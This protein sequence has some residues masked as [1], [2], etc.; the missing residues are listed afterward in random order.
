MELQEDG[1]LL[2]RHGA[3]DLGQGSNS[4]MCEIAAR[5]FGVDYDLVQGITGDTREGKDGGITAASRQTHITG[6]AAFEVSEMF[7]TTL[8]KYAAE[9]Y[10]ADP[11]R[12]AVT[13]EGDLIDLIKEEPV[14]DLRDLAQKVKEREEELSVSHHYVPQQTYRILNAQQRKEADIDEDAYINYPAFCYGCQVAV[15][16]VDL[17]TGQVDVIKMIAAHDAGTAILP[18]SVE[19]QIEGGVVMGL[20][21]ALTEE[22]VEEE[23]VIISDSLYKLTAPRSTNPADVE[24]IIVEDP[25]PRGPFGAKGVGEGAYMPTAP[26]VINAIDNATGIR[27]RSIPATRDKIMAAILEERQE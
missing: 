27:I 26:A 5:A 22:F 16:E 11:E 15:V 6:Q 8:L 7:K 17:E 12:L 24:A 23:G 18:T 25:H 4:A 19:G 20:G 21:Y 1:T 10:G 9:A 3:I 14:G 2:L 13:E